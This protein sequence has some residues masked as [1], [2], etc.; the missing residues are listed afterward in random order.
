MATMIPPEL[1]SRKD[2]DIPESERQIFKAL[3]T[4]PRHWVVLHSVSVPGKR[5]NSNPREADFVIMAPGAGAVCLEVKGDSYDVRNGQWFRQSGRSHAVAGPQPPTEQAK[6]TMDAVK[7]YLQ[8][9]ASDPSR[10][11]RQ[12]I[13]Q[14]PLWYAVAFTDGSW[15]SDVS[16]PQCDIYDDY[17]C[18]SPALLCRALEKLLHDLPNRRSS[19]IPL[20][21][22]TIDFIRQALK[23]DISMEDHTWTNSFNRSLRVLVQLTEKQSEV[24]RLVR[25][26]SN[27]RVILEGGAG[28]GKTLLAIKRAKEVAA[29][30][31]RVALLCNRRK[32]AI[33]MERSLGTFG[34]VVVRGRRGFL[35]WIIDESPVS[36]SSALGQIALRLPHNGDPGSAEAMGRDIMRDA[37]ARNA[38]KAV[39]GKPPQF[40]Y[41]IIDEFQWFFEP[42]TF[43][44]LDK[45]LVGGLSQ[46]S[47][48]FF[49]DFANQSS[50]R[51]QA[52][53]S[54]LPFIDPV[55][56][57]QVMDAQWT[58]DELEE[59]C[60][61]TKN[62]FRMMQRFDASG[63]PYRMR[64][65]SVDGTAVRVSKFGDAKELR[66]LLNEEITA[67][68]NA[69]VDGSQIV[70]L[71]P[72]YGGIEKFYL[73]SA[74]GF[75]PHNLSLF[76]ISTDDDVIAKNAFTFCRA[77]DYAG[78][79]SDTVIVLAAWPPA[80]D[81][82]SVDALE[83]FRSE[84]YI[85]LSRPKGG[86]IVLVEQGMPKAFAQHL[87]P[88]S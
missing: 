88:V 10:K 50:L 1:P 71:F 70:V 31:K 38:V 17:V 74:G 2:S 39:E 60:R 76:D 34:N 49:A 67:L 19:N 30:G 86:L 21:A 72:G 20:T 26:E 24:L 6:D 46:G 52:R 87:T 66:Y 57:L 41:L 65:N 56:A 58:S 3:K 37:V 63:T 48:L 51:D 62:I 9:Q 32:Q 36:K 25:R 18:K 45:V 16:F 53:D 13:N 54:G 85:A 23:P 83:A 14:M 47:W 44:V 33:H 42:N 35:N 55:E 7:R 69:G 43:D 15:P 84:L 79:E 5:R 82:K 8:K 80:L 68:S 4:G 78:L 64:P 27:K 29:S 40:D 12:R 11:F 22:D 75:G 59:N 28:T 61:N 73:N 81:P 77:R